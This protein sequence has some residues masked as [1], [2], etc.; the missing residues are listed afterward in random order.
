[1]EREHEISSVLVLFL[2]IVYIQ[3]T[4]VNCFYYLVSDKGNSL[5]YN[6]AINIIP[7]HPHS[8]NIHK[9]IF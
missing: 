7:P 4:M 6:T 8:C 5:F 9:N 3:Y 1:M 2:I